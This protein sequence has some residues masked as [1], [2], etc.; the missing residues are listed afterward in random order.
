[1]NFTY[2]NHSSK[3]IAILVT[4][5]SFN[6]ITVGMPTKQYVVSKIVLHYSCNDL[7]VKIGY[8]S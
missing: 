5:N 3:E 4:F 1:M 6:V 8:L 7:F 2:V